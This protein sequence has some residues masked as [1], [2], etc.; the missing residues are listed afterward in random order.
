[1]YGKTHHRRNWSTAPFCT[2]ISMSLNFECPDKN[3]SDCFGY[4]LH[5][6]FFLIEFV[7]SENSICTCNRGTPLLGVTAT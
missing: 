1:M 6:L 3:S 4:S 2:P 5:S 7:H